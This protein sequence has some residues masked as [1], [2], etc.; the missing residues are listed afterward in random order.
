[1]NEF[2]EITFPLNLGKSL[3]YK[4][5]DGIKASHCI[6]RRVLAPLNNKNTIGFVTGVNSDNQDFKVLPI[7]KFMDERAIFSQDLLK[8]FSWIAN[9]YMCPLGLVLK[10]A[11]PSGYINS[12]K[13]WVRKG[14]ALDLFSG[15][16]FSKGTKKY[17]VTQYLISYPNK[18]L[19]KSLQK[20]IS[21]KSILPSLKE[22]AQDDLVELIERDES[23]NNIKYEKFVHFDYSVFEK[24]SDIE[25]QFKVFK[26]RSEHQKNIINYFLH[27][28]NLFG[29]SVHI[30][31]LIKQCGAAKSSIDSL[32]RKGIVKIIKQ[33]TD[34]S[35]NDFDRSISL[36]NELTHRANLEQKICINEINKSLNENEF[37]AFL[38]HGITG[39][40]KTM[41]YI[42]IMKYCFEKEGD[43]PAQ[44]LLLVP[45]ISLS[46]Q[47]TDRFEKAFP[48]QVFTYHS[49]MSQGAKRDCYDNILS[50]T[51]RIVVGTRS[52]IFAPFRNLKL[53]IIDEEHDISFK[54]DRPNPRYNARDSAVARARFENITIVLGSATPSLESYHNATGGKYKLLEIKYRAD[55]ARLPDIKIIDILEAK[56]TSQVKGIFSLVLLSAIQKRIAKKQQVILFIN[57]RGFS[58]ML[59]CS[60][61]GNVPLCP[62]CDIALSYHKNKQKLRCHC[63]GFSKYAD[64]KCRECNND[65]LT[66]I[67]I[68]TQKVEEQLQDILNE[69]GVEIKIKR[70]D[71]DNIPSQ[72]KLHNE[73]NKFA[74]GK[75]D[76]LIGTQMISKGLDFK[77]VTLVGV[78]NADL[79]LYQP[80]FRAS[81]RTFQMLTQV[82]GR[83]GRDRN[84]LGEV[85][86]QTNKPDNFAI[87]Y[88]KKHSYK[89]F[90]IKELSHRENAFWSPF[91][92]FL[93]IKISSE[94]HPLA[95][96]VA[97]KFYSSIEECNF[98]RKFEP[99]APSLEYQGGKYYVQIVLKVDKKIDL[100][101]GKTRKLLNNA[102]LKSNINQVLGKISFSID[103][104][105]QSHL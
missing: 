65:K 73:L 24:E 26:I 19:V 16:K 62:N 84:L 21:F 50:G 54:Q 2:L 76:L 38:L 13:I 56:K 10:A 98:L 18:I 30:T 34:R 44:I 43:K 83:A 25:S 67:G 89:D 9:Y 11:L 7:T 48:Q 72:K 8:F 6:G 52:S 37:K 71:S 96:S 87:N 46:N 74:N 12:A 57:R 69:S 1:M 15:N 78:I 85:I 23:G 33:R 31:N 104:D 79:A 35:L 61:C 27:D 88:V 42:N 3:S 105:S 22:L 81:E 47:L 86:I 49:A 51:A 94:N 80:D 90:Y 60:S 70:I 97:Q 95:Q 36:V 58:V 64:V 99:Q 91:A 53:I 14:V 82:A 29:T 40:G 100:S 68:G 92:R 103:I 39:S 17:A 75:Y 45:E 32:E 102:I 66:Q 77:N 20:K 28:Y 93:L 41:V 63:C 101:G 55:G 59:E 4:T 5:P